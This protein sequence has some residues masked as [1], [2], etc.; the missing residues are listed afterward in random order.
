MSLKKALS[1]RILRFLLLWTCTT[2]I[3]YFLT[4]NPHAYTD[5]I[6]GSLIL[7][8]VLAG[9]TWWVATHTS[10]GEEFIIDNVVY[11]TM[12][13]TI[14]AVGKERSNFL[15]SD[16]GVAAWRKSCATFYQTKSGALFSVDHSH[17]LEM[18]L[19]IPIQKNL[20]SQCA[21]YAN[22][23][24]CAA[25]MVSKEYGNLSA[26]ETSRATGVKFTNA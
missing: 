4:F 21:T 10:K 13:A 5:N 18:A 16:W 1:S 20:R 6:Q 19:F 11:D 3:V 14:I 24:E 23:D 22:W 17:V 25:A 12:S 2:L 15:G 7:G 26:R 8:V 9:F